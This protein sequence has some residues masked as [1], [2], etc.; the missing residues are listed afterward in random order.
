MK[1]IHFNLIDKKIMNKNADT[2]N[3]CLRKHAYLDYIK[4]AIFKIKNT[5]NFLYHLL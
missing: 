1:F 5:K 3:T 4:K 2:Y